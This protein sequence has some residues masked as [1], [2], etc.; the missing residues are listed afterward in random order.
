M[1]QVAVPPSWMPVGEAETVITGGV[2]SEITFKVASAWVPPKQAN[3]SNP[4]KSPKRARYERTLPAGGGR[5]ML[6]RGLGRLDPLKP[7]FELLRYCHVPRRDKPFVTQG[8]IKANSSTHHQRE[9]LPITPECRV[10]GG[11]IGGSHV[12]CV[13]FYHH[14]P[15]TGERAGERKPIPERGR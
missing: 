2:V 5:P 6:D 13:A 7:L 3:S 8:S 11:G 15:R 1:V 14:I 9:G 4:N 12:G 10:G